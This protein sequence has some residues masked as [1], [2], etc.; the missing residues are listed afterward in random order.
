MSNRPIFDFGT[1]S[2]ELLIIGKHYCRC[3]P[4]KPRHKDQLF[5][6]LR[7]SHKGEWKLLPQRQNSY[8]DWLIPKCCFINATCL[9]VVGVAGEIQEEYPT[10]EYVPEP[11]PTIRTTIEMYNFN[12]NFPHST[13][14]SPPISS[15]PR[16]KI[17]KTDLLD[18]IFNQT[19]ISIGYNEVYLTGGFVCDTELFKRNVRDHFGDREGCTTLKD[20]WNNQCKLFS[21]KYCNVTNMVFQGSCLDITQS[22][23]W[24]EIDSLVE[25][26]SGHVSFKMGNNIYIAGGVGDQNQ[27]HKLNFREIK[28]RNLS[29][30]ER[31]N[32]KERKWENCSYIVPSCMAGY[33][34]VTSDSLNVTVSDDEKFAIITGNVPCNTMKNKIVIFTEEGGFI[35]HDEN[36]F[37]NGR[38]QIELLLA[39]EIGSTFMNGGQHHICLNLL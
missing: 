35:V 25:S 4:R 20:V 21:E 27:K 17:L 29:S 33:S 26:R 32:L 3:F 10:L 1:T 11:S 22:I 6:R 31:Y 13:T 36:S 2:E 9:L 7:S 30:C 14:N 28:R 19:L 39:A 24:K 38:H 18:N 15:L 5:S 23:T 34:G 12:Q 37:V 8:E 16:W